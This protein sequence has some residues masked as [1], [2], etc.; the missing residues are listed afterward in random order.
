MFKGKK[1]DSKGYR[2]SCR[3]G[4]A[5]NFIANMQGVLIKIKDDLS[6]SI[7][8]IN[9][10]EGLHKLLSLSKFPFFSP[11]QSA[12]YVLWDVQVNSLHRAV[13]YFNA[14]ENIFLC[15]FPSE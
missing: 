5:N 9:D 3:K 1:R 13:G 8:F 6:E 12:K 14:R 7:L 11:S 4:K 15:I 10:E 2:N